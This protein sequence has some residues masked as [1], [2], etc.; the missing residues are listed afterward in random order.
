M[1]TK[2]TTDGK[3][4]IVV[5]QINNNETI[6]QEIFVTESGDEVPSGERFVTKSLHDAPVVSYQ[7]KQETKLKESIS[8]LEARKDSAYRDVELAK[9]QLLIHK[10]ILKSVKK[11]TELVPE[12]ELDVF[13]GFL[14]GT[15]EY[16]VV[17]SYKIT[18][19]VKMMAF[20]PSGHVRHIGGY[21]M[22]YSFWIWGNGCEVILLNYKKLAADLISPL[23]RL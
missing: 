18:A 1:E 6:V 3:K 20:I 12:E 19:P 22:M 21:S 4:V 7:I 23:V 5:G 8:A 9:Q 15:I 17:D 10:D 2:Y 14:T 11:F 16:L 13:T